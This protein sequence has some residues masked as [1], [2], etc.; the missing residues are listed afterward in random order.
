MKV[1]KL[2]ISNFRNIE[3]LILEPCEKVNVIWGENAQGKT[4]ILE[5][6]WLFCGAKSFRGA[7]DNELIKKDCEESLIS[8]IFE[9]EE[10]EK[11]AKIK[12]GELKLDKTTA[13][14]IRTL[15]II[16]I[17]RSSTERIL[18]ALM[19]KFRLI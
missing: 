18:F 12:A 17:M 11:E 10:L 15:L 9:S 14:F 3:K 19:K 5:A 2:E 1:K 6:V 13:T 16:A 8:L 4:N 7:K